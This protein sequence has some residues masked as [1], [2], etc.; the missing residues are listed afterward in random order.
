MRRLELAEKARCDSPC[1][2]RAFFNKSHTCADTVAKVFVG[3]RRF[4]RALW[5]KFVDTFAIIFGVV[6]HPELRPSHTE[7]FRLGECLRRTP[8]LAGHAI[9]RYDQSRSI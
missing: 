9:Q 5:S 3:T 1:P 2:E 8:S 6:A 4:E 7:A